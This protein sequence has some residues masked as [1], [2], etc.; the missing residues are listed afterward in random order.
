MIEEQS[1]QALVAQLQAYLDRLTP[2]AEPSPEPPDL[3][4]LLAEMMALKTE[5]KRES[6]IF[7]TGLDEFRA[8]FTELEQNRQRFQ[9]QQEQ[10]TALIAKLQTEQTEARTLAVAEAETELLREILELR[11]RMQAGL[12][13]TRRYTPPADRKPPP[14]SS[15]DP[16]PKP[17]RRLW[18]FARI[19]RRPTE[20]TGQQI[21]SMANS[22]PLPGCGHGHEKMANSMT[23]SMATDRA[24][25]A[26]AQSF[27]AAMTEGMAMNLRRLDQ[28]L[29]RYGV[30]PLAVQ[31]QPFNANTMLAAD[32]AH[33]AELPEGHVVEILRDGFL[34]HERLL[35]IAEVIVN[36]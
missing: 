25:L 29:A 21:D 3:F 20:V 2:P 30:Q 32:T 4:T 24:A 27:I 1:K 33:V 23:A 34:R 36:K 14:V 7:K 22:K 11:D 31:G 12:D 13:Q 19:E 26:H 35:R 15:A 6:R 8:L 18:P 10:Q 16:A 5:V 9:T 28:M 17:R